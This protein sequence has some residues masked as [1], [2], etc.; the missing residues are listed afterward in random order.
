MSAIQYQKTEDHIVILTFDSPNQSANTMNAD[1]RTALEE[2]VAQ[3]QADEQIAGIIFRSA[4]KTFFAGGDLDE[5]IQATPEHATEFFNMIEDMKAKLRYI[6]TRGIPVMAALNGTA[7][8]GG[9][10]IAL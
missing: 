4:K 6:E 2:V 10:E 1:F 5:L 8:G 9:W 7:L 3:L